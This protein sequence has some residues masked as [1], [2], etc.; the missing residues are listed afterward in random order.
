MADSRVV[1][2]T[3]LN[4][5]NL[6]RG[7]RQAAREIVRLTDEWV[8]VGKSVKEQSKHVEKLKNE[9]ALAAKEAEELK[10][11]KEAVTAL[12]E[13][14]AYADKLSDRYDEQR[15][16]LDNLSADY[17]SIIAK[18][19]ELVSEISGLEGRKEYSLGMEEHY[20]ELSKVAEKEKDRIRFAQLADERLA[21]A[22][23]T[24]REMNDMQNSY[25]ES[26]SD[27]AEAQKVLTEQIKEQEAIVGSL[28][29]KVAETNY[30]YKALADQTVNAYKEATAISSEAKAR[31]D[32]EA[33]SL[34]ELEA[35]H[36]KI[37]SALREAQS[38]GRADY[39]EAAREATGDIDAFN[40][41]IQELNEELSKEQDPASI[42]SLRHELAAT[43]QAFEQF[44]ESISEPVA[45]IMRINELT[46]QIEA[47]KVEI[48]EGVKI[49]V[50]YSQI[51]EAEAK[52]Q[53]LQA[54][55]E[56]I[57]AKPVANEI[58]TIGK[59]ITAMGSAMQN[60]RLSARQMGAALGMMVGG[61]GTVRGAIS[62]ISG[63]VFMMGGA[64]DAARIKATAMWAAITLGVSLVINGITKIVEI[65]RRFTDKLQDITDSIE[66][67]V[68]RLANAISNFI[69]ENFDR[70]L[71]RI[72]R[73]LRGIVSSI[74]E[75]AKNLRIFNF[76]IRDS[77]R[78]AQRLF[79]NIMNLARSTF[80]FGQLRNAINDVMGVMRSWILQSDVFNNQL[81][82][83]RVNLLTAFQPIVEVVIPILYTF[84]RVLAAATSLLAQFLSMLFG[85]SF[86]QSREAAKAMQRQAAGIGAV[87]GA[88]REANKHLAKFD[89]INQAT[90]ESGG[91]GGAGSGWDFDV[92]VFE[93][94]DWITNLAG[95]L[96]DTFLPV[97]DAM[98]RAWDAL[99][100]SMLTTWD[101][102]GANIVQSWQG[103]VESI[104][105]LLSAVFN[106]LEKL[107]NSDEW[108]RFLGEI[109]RLIIL[110]GDTISAVFDSLTIA[111]RE[112]DRG[113]RLLESIAELWTEIVGFV[114]DFGRSLVNAWDENNRG[115]GMLAS[116]L[117]AWTDINLGV[118]SLIGNLRNAWNEG[119]R[120][121]RIWG[122]ILRA[123]DTFLV[124]IRE[125]TRIFKEWADGV[126]F[127]PLIAAFEKLTEAL[128]PLVGVM[129]HKLVD[130]F[131][132]L[133]D[134]TGDFIET[135]LPGFITRIADGLDRM[136]DALWKAEN[137][138]DF[139]ATLLSELGTIIGELL[140]DIPWGTILAG[141][142]DGVFTLL[143]GLAAAI[144]NLLN[145]VSGNKIGAALG[146]GLNKIFE[147][148]DRW[149]NIADAAGNIVFWIFDLIA[150]AISG[151][152]PREAARVLG[153][154]IHRFLDKVE[155]NI[156]DV[157]GTI[158]TIVDK[159]YE[160]LKTFLGSGALDRA[161]EMAEEIVKAIDFEKV[162]ELV[163]NIDAIRELPSRIFGIIKDEFMAGKISSIFE[164]IGSFIG[165]NLIPLLLLPIQGIPATILQM[166]ASSLFRKDLEDSGEN[167]VL[168][169]LKGIV[170][171]IAG[172]GTWIQENI[173]LP[174]WNGLKSAIMP[175]WE[176]GR[177]IISGV[178]EGILGFMENVGAWIR[179]NIFVPIW[180]GIKSAF[181]ISS[182]ASTMMEIGGWI[183]QGLF[184][185]ILGGIGAIVGLATDIWEGIKGV[186][187]A[188][189][190]WFGDRFTAAKNAVENAWSRVGNWFGD[191]WSDIQGAFATTKNWFSTTFQTA[192]DNAQ[193]AFNT[194]RT[195]F[196]N[197]WSD[198]QSAFSNTRTWFSTTFQTARDNAQNAFN[199]VKGWF[200]NRW[201]D[202]Q[203]AFSNVST[204]FRARFTEGRTSMEGAFSTN[205]VSNFFSG[206]WGTIQGAF[207]DATSWF[208]NIGGS[209]M[210]GLQSG[211]NNAASTVANA[212]TSVVQGAVNA[213]SNLLR[214]S[215]PS[216]L[217]H[218]LIGLNMGYGIAEGLIDS[219]SYIF[220]ALRE[221]LSG[222][223]GSA[224]K[225][226]LV[227]L[228]KDMAFDL[229]EGM[230]QAYDP[231][232][233]FFKSLMDRVD[234]IVSTPIQIPR[235]PQ[236][237]GNI[238]DSAT[239]SMM[240]EKGRVSAPPR[241]DDNREWLNLIL[242]RLEAIEN[243]IGNITFEGGSVYLNG[244]E[245]ARI[246]YDDFAAEAKRRG[247][248][249][250]GN[251]LGFAR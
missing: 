127:R 108:L 220:K 137:P 146:E 69:K 64:F 211:I 214:I 223:Q 52:I 222:L 142:I 249:I 95:W 192:R 128:E 198:I 119:E 68:R 140:S 152:N 194:V 235:I 53:E 29:K 19:K 190:D 61:A 110:I 111:W 50:D 74:I 40:K 200:S 181:G 188:V 17:D 10:P 1:I 49:G 225:F 84:M 174:F 167:I 91:S 16:I 219:A 232:I 114:N 179:D 58:N 139:V 168:G 78:A 239:I 236:L 171:K 32:E 88:A 5:K 73:G 93:M 89:E 218:D 233:D 195:F 182:P 155:N 104:A 44:K 251:E 33:K 147:D 12:K 24:A 184:Q 86:A 126:N 207:S 22:I 230:K 153:E 178:F 57:Q 46:E 107:F 118:R 227:S 101:R 115:I 208:S 210:S 97:F 37:A 175:W 129:M 76:D 2:D 186:F 92:P 103:A 77:A 132:S 173:L 150:G 243:A 136:T 244:R 170:E 71:A 96:R 143:D 8:S 31:Y 55:L 229:L 248:R 172:I 144:T 212:A 98:G 145:G 59:E 141:I 228:G 117:G 15:K 11:T 151:F 51:A 25:N 9:Y 159:I 161:V 60:S 221:T 180:E 215:S 72:N 6:I 99:L 80:V 65:F 166:V 213:A 130:W 122:N 189:G 48:G 70:V 202:I 3:S 102:W 36:K 176:I 156:D 191:R 34:N 67:A 138:I 131:G 231:I 94:P 106:D 45:D 247:F 163:K 205:T 158:S 196:S 23:A 133:L 185:G 42:V 81:N 121:E 75:S 203:S 20:R 169:M 79:R 4:N 177:D 124:Y 154:A 27:S 164:S 112:N 134:I 54:E 7:V 100:A 113:Y 148:K 82:Q 157:K 41:R 250:N 201:S 125:A 28:A 43:E 13:M 85:T 39:G 238:V 234:T 206:V 226:S 149:L 21:D 224:N 62:G 109:A 116:I 47:L 242:N 63:M 241:I 105:R 18:Q 245:I 30:E 199:T 87:G 204:W 123:V 14:Q 183:I 66:A 35:S 246:T 209:M 240:V 120:G 56:A 135:G 216:K 38:L 83:I 193:N 187:S 237:T 162:W 165:Q 90:A 160:F 197:R 26:V 217:M